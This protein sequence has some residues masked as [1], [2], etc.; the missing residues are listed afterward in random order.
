M[1]KSMTAFARESENDA[2]GE[3][4][5]ELRT[6][7][8]RFLEI[9]VRLPEELRALET[10]VRGRI[11]ARLRRGKVDCSL[12]WSP[13]K[14]TSADLRVNRPLVEALLAALDDVAGMIGRG[15]EPAPLELLRWPGVIQEPERDLDAVS[16]AALGVLER[17]LDGLIGAREREGER[18]G[19]MLRERCELLG[20]C[21]AR[22]RERMPMVI[23]GVRQR[24]SDRLSEIRGELD[25]GRLEQE[26]ALLA[27]RLDVDEEMDRL[28]AHVAEV[29]DVLGRDEPIGRR[30]DFLMQELNREANTLGSKSSDVEVTRESVE[31]KVPIEQMREQVQ[32]LE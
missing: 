24:L 13:A 12:R 15:G 11:T 31:M 2:I 32:N 23:D 8:H 18:L 3:L 5:W 19:V 29:G 14:G 1:I 30:L 17:T 9:H 21:V 27:A 7:N 6:V 16:A 22:V 4:V 10:A 28:G 25:P 20:R 26:M